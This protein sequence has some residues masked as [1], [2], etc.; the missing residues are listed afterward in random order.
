M[1][2]LE[3][4]EEPTRM[5]LPDP[6]GR[7][8]SSIFKTLKGLADDVAPSDP[9]TGGSPDEITDG[10]LPDARLEVTLSLVTLVDRLG[11]VSEGFF[12]N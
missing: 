1:P 6:E 3:A 8:L 7:L 5:A 11:I 10:L 12:C 4:L 2:G 9:G